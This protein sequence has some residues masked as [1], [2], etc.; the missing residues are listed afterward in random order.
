VI[1]AL[2]VFI[3]F[4]ILD[5]YGHKTVTGKEDLQGQTALVKERL[6]P[7][8]T[9]L[10]QGEYWNAVSRSGRIEPGEEVIIEQVVGLKL[11]VT[12]RGSQEKEEPTLR[13][14]S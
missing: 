12:K 1:I 5:T 7:E 13:E 9:V 3:V 11:Y 2:L 6:D 8:G 4:R 14:D 10:F